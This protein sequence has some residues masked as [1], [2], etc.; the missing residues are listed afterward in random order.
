MLAGAT[1]VRTYGRSIR[2]YERVRL[3]QESSVVNEAL[4]LFI[5]PAQRY[6]M[7]RVSQQPRHGMLTTDGGR[8]TR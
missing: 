5:A 2:R 6:A 3:P 8:V 7:A 4:P 1:R